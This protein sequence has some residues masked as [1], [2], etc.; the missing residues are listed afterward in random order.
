MLHAQDTRIS[1]LPYRGLRPRRP[2]ELEE[3]NLI[4]LNRDIVADPDGRNEA[5]KTAVKVVTTTDRGA[6]GIEVETSAGTWTFPRSHVLVG[7]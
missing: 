6:L 3:G 2:Y 7:I 5:L 1:E 4:D